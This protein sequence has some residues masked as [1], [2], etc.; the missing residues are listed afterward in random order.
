[1]GIFLRRG[2][3]RLNSL[4]IPPHRAPGSVLYALSTLLGA[5]GRGLW[6]PFSLLYFHYV[7][8]FP[9]PLV[10]VGLTLAG[11][12]GMAITPLTG[13]LVDRFGARLLYIL[14]FLLMGAGTLGYLMAHTF[15]IFLVAAMI[16]QSAWACIG[17]AGS[18]YIAELFPKEDHDWWFGFNRSSMNLGLSVGVLLAGGIASIGGRASYQWLLIGSSLGYIVT[19]LLIFT[20]PARRG[21]VTRRTSERGERISYL[22]VLRDLP[23]LGFVVTQAILFLSY[24][25][26]EVAIPP[27]LVG[28]VHAPTWSF[29]LLFTLNTIMVVVFQVPLM[30]VLNRFRRAQGIAAGG[31]TYALSY[32]LFAVAALL[33]GVALVPFLVVSMVIYTLGE[34]FLSPPSYAL[35]LALA[36]ERA[37]GRYMAVFGLGGQ[38]AFTLAPVFFTSALTFNIYVFWIGFAVLTAAT[39]GAVLLLERRLPAHTQRATSEE[40]GSE[41]AVEVRREAKEEPLVV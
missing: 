32:L 5:L 19:G 23:F 41:L 16:T 15:P 14:G 28:N 31:F 30:K 20:I 10:G 40:P 33:P 1:M 26:L 38:L 22:T 25:I 2:I 13:S 12:W 17:P 18:A 27:F 35:G 3:H 9:L 37:R 21:A 7:I 4:F 6:L 39:A 36:P 11:F 29:S 24:T 8:G 34:L